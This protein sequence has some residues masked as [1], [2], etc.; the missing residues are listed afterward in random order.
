METV[1]LGFLLGYVMSLAFIGVGYVIGVSVGKG[2]N[3]ET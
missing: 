3:D 2:E 1:V